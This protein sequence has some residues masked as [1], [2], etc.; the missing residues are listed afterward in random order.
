L[1]KSSASRR[2][3]RALELG[4]LRTEEPFLRGRAATL[5]LAEPL[6]DDLEVIPTR[7]RLE[8]ELSQAP[9]RELD[10]G[11]ECAGD[12]EGSPNEHA[13]RQRFVRGIR[14]LTGMAQ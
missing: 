2:A 13:A 7:T 3:H 12:R 14:R 6:P 9:P 1:D 4:Y 5:A 11:V 10:R 8:H